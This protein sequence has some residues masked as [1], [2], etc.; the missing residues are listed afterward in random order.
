M[1]HY[2]AIFILGPQ[3]SGKGTQAKIL[4][5]KLGFLSWDTGAILRK[6]ADKITSSGELAGDILKSGRL[7]TDEELMSV[8]K[9]ELESLPQDQGIVFDSFPRRVGQEKVVLDFL[10]KR[11]KNSFATVLLQLPKEE[12]LNRLM[13]RA[14]KEGRA[15][16]ARAAIEKRLQEYEDK[17]VPMLDLLKSRTDFFEV[18]GRPA[19]P[20]VEKGVDRALGLTQ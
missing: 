17:T 1:K 18:D 5:E 7:F 2:D 11:G 19:V 15:D 9:E 16:D 12:C 13:L 14:E 8:V 4:A 20:E 6:N 3:G 10:A